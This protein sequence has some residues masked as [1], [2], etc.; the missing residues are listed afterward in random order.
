MVVRPVIQQKKTPE[1][2]P[3]RMIW[4]WQ[5]PVSPMDSVGFKMVERPVKGDVSKSIFSIT[6]EVGG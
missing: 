1:D 6:K 2:A 3:L 4:T 5:R